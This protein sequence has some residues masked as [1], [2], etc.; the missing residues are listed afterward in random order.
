[1]NTAAS[2]LLTKINN[3]TLTCTVTIADRT[4]LSTVANKR[5]VGEAF[6]NG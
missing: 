3:M 1:M 5:K 4:A 2:M 6:G